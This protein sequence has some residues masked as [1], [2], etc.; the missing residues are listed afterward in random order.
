MPVRPAGTTR[1]DYFLDGRP[2]ACDA[3][4]CLWDET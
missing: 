1:V 4:C 3:T 2:I